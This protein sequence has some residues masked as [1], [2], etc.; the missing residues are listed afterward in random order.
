MQSIG[1]Q[2]MGP[3][4]CHCVVFLVQALNLHSDLEV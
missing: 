2:I 1:A 3:V 4:Q